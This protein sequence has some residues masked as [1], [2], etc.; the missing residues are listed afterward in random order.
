MDA[1]IKALIL[2]YFLCL[3]C[4]EFYPREHFIQGQ[5]LD[6]P[7]TSAYIYVRFYVKLSGVSPRRYTFRNKHHELIIM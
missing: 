3:E 1:P 7:P 5:T 4:A 6:Q 2:N